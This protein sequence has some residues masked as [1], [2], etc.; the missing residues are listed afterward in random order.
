[1][2]NFTVPEIN[3]MCI[4]DTSSKETLLSDLNLCKDNVYE[5]EMIEL[6]KTTI[7][8]L[9]KITDEEFSEIGFFIADEFIDFEDSYD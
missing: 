3:L 6:I 4:L 7:K 8:K 9:E 1:M 5:P 2:D